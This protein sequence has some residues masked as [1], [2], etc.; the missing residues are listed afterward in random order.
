MS[1]V[2]VR[3]ALAQTFKNGSFFADDKVAWENRPFTPPKDEPWAT[4]WFF[5]VQPVVASLGAGGADEQRGFA[6]ID[7]NYP[8]G[9]G[10][11]DI[12]A[13]AVAIGIVFKAGARFAY[14][15]QEVVILS[16]GCSEGRIVN[17]YY[18]VSITIQFYAHI[19]R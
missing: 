7:L 15:G 10:V 19:T 8:Q 13:K 2:K 12:G 11:A 4:F 9:D 5:P 17:G 3:N 1:V 6:Q 16:C 18:R 14:S